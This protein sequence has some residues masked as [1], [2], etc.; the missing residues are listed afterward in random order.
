MQTT[1]PRRANLRTERLDADVAVLAEG[2]DGAD[3][4]EPH[5]E[6]ARHLLREGD[7]AVEAVTQHDVEEHHGRH[8]GQEAHERPLEKARDQGHELVRHG[9]SDPSPR[10]PP[11]AKHGEPPAD[12]PQTRAG[13]PPAL[14]AWPARV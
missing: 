1:R 7:A 14:R 13:L 3:E 8:A 4:G 9:A 11:G 2:E 12:Q 10:L 5:E 6:V